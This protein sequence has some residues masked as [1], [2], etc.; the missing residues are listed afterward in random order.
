LEAITTFFSKKA[1]EKGH[2]VTLIATKGSSMSDAWI[3]AGNS[4]KHQPVNIMETIEPFCDDSQDELSEWRHYVMYKD[5]LE[6]KYGEGQ[7]IVWDNTF[8]CYPYLS[9]RKFPKMKILHTHHSTFYTHYKTLERLHIPKDFKYPRFVGLSRLHA[10]YMSSVINKPVK[11]VHNGIPL[12]EAFPKND[13]TLENRYGQPLLSLNRI[14]P[15][16]GIDSAIDIAIETGNHIN[17]VGNDRFSPPDYVATIK[18]KCQN[19]NGHAKYYGLVDN[20]TKIQLL[21]SCRAIVSCPKPTWMEAF[22]LYA[23][24]ANA[25]GKPVLALRNGGLG[26]IVVNGV[27]G[28]LA[29]NIE[30]LKGYVSELDMCD[31]AACRRRVKEMFTDEI[32]TNN[33]LSIFEKVLYYNGCIW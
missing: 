13:A 9:A 32:M 8:R 30:Q 11:Y 4:K 21:K 14:Y 10:K 27:N 20:L 18:E 33:Y 15:E 2:S 17:V 6:K 5:L 12:P 3:I 26:D 16:K 25:Y 19:S 29:E 23:V 28:F 1:A 24:E 31:P 7:G 22:G